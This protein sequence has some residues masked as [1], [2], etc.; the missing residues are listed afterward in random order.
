MRQARHQLDALVQIHRSP[1]REARLAAWRR[2][3]AT[4]AAEAADRRPVPL[5]GLNPR[6]LL[7]SVRV[8]LADGLL[9]DLRWLS[10][11]HAAAALYE[12]AAVVPVGDERRELGRR[13][14]QRLHQGNAAT[15]VALAT[16][17]AQ[18]SRRALS[19]A[20][21]RARVSLCLDLP[22]GSAARADDLA[23]ALL[24]RP[25]LV[26]EWLVGPS[27]GSLPS[28]R[29]ASKLLER[30]AREVAQRATRDD[31]GLV[32]LFQQPDVEAAWARLLADREPLVWRHVASA[33]GLL[34]ELIPRFGGEIDR[35]LDAA[36]TPTEWRRAAASLTATI[37]LHP[38]A[39]M[40]RCRRL[41]QGEVYRKDPGIVSAM[42][43]GAAIAAE[44][45]PAAVESL[46]N[47]LVPV[48]GFDAMEALVELRQERLDRSYASHA[49]ELA[50]R[51]I[52]R[53]EFASS[54]DDGRVAL[55]QVLDAELNGSDAAGGVVALRQQLFE[56][57]C[58]FEEHSARAAHAHAI[59]VI[60]ALDD[61]LDRLETS[62]DATRAG[63]I[64]AFVTLRE[65]DHALLE[66]SALSDLLTLGGGGE[67]ATGEPL[68][69][70]FE[71]LT[72]W[73]TRHESDPIL[74]SEEVAHTT[75]RINRL[76]AVLHLVD[77]DASATEERDARLRERRLRT[78]RL[79]LE[80]TRDDVPSP[81]RRVVAASAAR[82]CDALLREEVGE[83]SDVLLLIVLHVSRAVDMATMAEAS[84]DPAMVSTLRAYAKLVDQATPAMLEKNPNAGVQA[85]RGLVAAMPAVGSPRVEALR[86]ALQNF[87]AS[88]A[89]L[90]RVGCLAE[91]SLELEG[92]GSVIAQFG[93]AASM[94]ARLVA[95]ARRRL[96]DWP[97]DDLPTCGAA[98][99]LVDI[100]V[101]HALRGNPAPLR[102]SV[103]TAIDTLS[104]E[105]PLHLAAVATDALQRLTALDVELGQERAPESIRAMSP[106]EP[107]L[108]AWLPPSRTLGGFYV[109]RQLGAGAVGSVFV[110][111][112]FEDRSRPNAPR[113]ALKVPEYGG[114]AAH[115][116]SEAEF[117]QLF[118]EEAGALLSIP[119]H[120]DLAHFVTFDAG[121][122][123]KPILVMELVEGPTLQRLIDT[124]VLDV[125]RAVAIL[126][127][128]AAGLEAMHAVGVGHLDAKPSNVILRNPDEPAPLSLDL[129]P[130][131]LLQRVSRLSNA[132]DLQSEVPVLVDFGLAGRKLRPG[133]ATAHYGAPEVWGHVPEGHDPRPM[134][135]DVYAFG[136]LIYE[137]LTS[138]ELFEGPNQLG[139]LTQHLTH[140]GNPPKVERLAR[141]PGLAPL[142][143]VLR[144]ALRGDPRMRG[145]MAEVRSSF[146]RLDLTR[147]PWPIL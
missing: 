115:T 77:A 144:L 26:R 124:R 14:L 18:G 110:A 75:L 139:I 60:E 147:F 104:D 3:L 11:P 8:A 39:A 146:S 19:G 36:L 66:T 33:R 71:R 103:A 116:L 81:L 47:D 133:C 74:P 125:S 96:G 112:R 64:T 51:R 143:E 93:S 46:L 58:A 138:E 40:D 5:E 78:A 121:A 80:R 108:P 17:L 31:D 43:L 122:K 120:P 85:L 4:L 118:R 41:L 123:P 142:A 48:G 73:L 94:L 140:D 126:D 65:I 20:G 145:T 21:V 1:D 135:A 54:P 38:D 100:G 76:R 101:E 27:I 56:A 141:Q 134:P 61:V 37:A 59:G 32:R 82:A 99:H 7:A 44:I 55:A 98:L 23:L 130:S 87:A 42:I 95:G 2:G 102:D 70:Y 12:L 52:R 119:H 88:I 128:I 49:A 97:S 50:S 28:R 35:D 34:S 91:A 67:S 86:F 15:F 137:T 57:R 22:I 127:G 9:D 117:L 111:C 29:L 63:R 131:G 92:A 53:A 113:Y 45:E 25:E 6:A 79:L 30:A 13:V 16:R 114:D 105:L 69:E 132:A 62:G 107:P 84:M 72:D 83:L 90:R 68:D 24:S 109:L 136:C 129:H 10:P 106:R 89:D